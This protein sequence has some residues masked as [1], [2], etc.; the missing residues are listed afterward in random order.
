[1]SIMLSSKKEYSVFILLLLI[2]FFSNVAFAQDTY[3]DT[4]PLGGNAW[5]HEPAEITDSGL[6]KWSDAKNA[7]SIYFSTSVPQTFNLTLR[8]QV[9]DGN[10]KIS[11]TY[12]NIHYS[13]PINNAEF[14]V[15]SIG[16]L[17]VNKPGYVK[18]DLIGISKT[19]AVFA[20]IS[21]LILQH[22]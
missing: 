13:K 15:I 21:D 12:G 22:D 9:P 19:G 17:Q 11:I 18:I 10:S 2:F 4:I 7:V 5:V 3:T 1:M 8:L 14:D 16:K 6:I 20:N